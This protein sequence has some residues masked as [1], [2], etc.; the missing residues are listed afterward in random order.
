MLL[1]FNPGLAFESA[2]N[3]FDILVMAFFHGRLLVGLWKVYR[4][5]AFDPHRVLCLSL[6]MVDLNMSATSPL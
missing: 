3:H 1:L 2:S 6:E 5:A 4:K